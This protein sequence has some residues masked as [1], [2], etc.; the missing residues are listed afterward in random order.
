MHLVRAQ[1]ISGC[2]SKAFP[3]GLLPIN[4]RCKEHTSKV[5]RKMGMSARGTNEKRDRLSH[6]PEPLTEGLEG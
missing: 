2:S 1:T 6:D 5:T 4:A 3:R